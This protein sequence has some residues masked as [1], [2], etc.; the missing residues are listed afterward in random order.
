MGQKTEIKTNL[1]AAYAL[2]THFGAINVIND[3]DE[4]ALMDAKQLLNGHDPVEFQAK[5]KDTSWLFNDLESADTPQNI[6]DIIEV[7]TG[8]YIPRNQMVFRITN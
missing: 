3:N 7:A 4:I 8:K 2:A 1:A 5:L 6:S